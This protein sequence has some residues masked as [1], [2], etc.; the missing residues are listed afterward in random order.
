MFLGENE[1]TP[2]QMSISESLSS[3]QEA[4]SQE[5]EAALYQLQLLWLDR[6]D[7]HSFHFS[8]GRVK[9]FEA[10]AVFLD[11]FSSLRN[12]PGKL[13]HQAGHRGRCLSFEFHAE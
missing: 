7:S 8:V 1:E 3:K 9:H 13:T 6:R 12:A 4:S 2:H 11:N 5:L 10:K